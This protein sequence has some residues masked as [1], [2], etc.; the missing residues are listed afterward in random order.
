MTVTIQ[1]PGHHV[2]ST[3]NGPEDTGIVTGTERIDGVLC[4]RVRFDDGHEG[5]FHPDVLVSV[6]VAHVPECE[7]CG[8]PA[9]VSGCRIP[10][11]ESDCPTHDPYF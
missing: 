10:K 11:H 2:Y 7:H 1:A 9:D 6:P 4:V 5:W 3:A 8:A